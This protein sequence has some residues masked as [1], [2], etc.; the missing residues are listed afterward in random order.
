MIIISAPSGAGKST[1][2]SKLV[3][4]YPEIIEN[5]SYT[6]RPPR[7]LE[8]DE[9]D[10]HFITKKEFDQ[11]VKEGFFI[12][13]AHVHGNDYGISRI[14]IETALQTGH[15][16]IFDIDVQGARTLLDKYPDSLTVFIL[17]PSIEELKRRLKERDKGRTHNFDLRIQNAEREMKEATFFKYK[18]VNAKLDQ[19]YAEL[20]KIVEKDL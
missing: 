15:P 5:I 3:K 18:I 12:E 2:C 16:I 11:K 8:K 14:Q 20:K 6:T 7:N 17:P 19:S 9:V 13:H 4:D 10:Y 1:L